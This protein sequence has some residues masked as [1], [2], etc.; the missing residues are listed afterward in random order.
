MLRITQDPGGAVIAEI[1][2]RLEIDESD[3]LRL[4][5]SQVISTHRQSRLVV[6]LT[7]IDYAEID[8]EDVWY[9]LKP[10]AFLKG[11]VRM[12]VLTE[13]ADV[14][15]YEKFTFFAPFRTRL[16]ALD[17]REEALAWVTSDDDGDRQSG[18]LG[19]T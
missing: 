11:L 17:E 5:L 4:T 19:R 1:N 3:E 15:A 10:A 2:K 6:V 9:D 7:D 13:P 18:P 16:F 12:A 8:P 14:P